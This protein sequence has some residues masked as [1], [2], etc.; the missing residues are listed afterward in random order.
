MLARLLRSIRSRGISL[1][2]QRALTYHRHY[3]YEECPRIASLLFQVRRAFER[4]RG[5]R[6]EGIVELKDLTVI[7]SNRAHSSRYEPTRA[8]VFLNILR[9]LEINYPEWV[10]ADL[11]S[12][13]GRTLLLAAQFPFHEVV[14]VEFAVELHEIAVR[15]VRR[16]ATRRRACSRIVPVCADAAEWELPR[17]KTLI[18]LYNPFDEKVMTQVVANIERALRQHA[19]DVQV[20]YVSPQHH[21][22]F[23]RSSMLRSVRSTD[24]YAVYRYP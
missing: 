8:R 17:G 12:G 16:F 15:N 23:E 2:L 7:G 6:S 18:Y 4:L 13:M 1:T 19:R 14:G 21:E 3:L 10:F 5:M 24:L 11:G 20:I 22:V 9:S